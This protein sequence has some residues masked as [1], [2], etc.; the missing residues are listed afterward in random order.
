MLVDS[1]LTLIDSSVINH[2]KNAKRIRVEKK[3]LKYVLRDMLCLLVEKAQ[4]FI[5]LN[6][7]E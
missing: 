6:Y 7:R 3:E 5:K 2:F 4:Y 1:K